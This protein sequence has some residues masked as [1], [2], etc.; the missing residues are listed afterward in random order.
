MAY[1]F[2]PRPSFKELPV[3]YN[4]EGAVGAQPAMNQREDVLL[5]QFILSFIAKTPKPTYSQAMIAA[6]NAVQLTGVADEATITAIREYQKL[7]PGWT[8]DGRVSPAKGYSYSGTMFAIVGLNDGLQNRAI[9]VWPRIDKIPGCPPELAQ[10]VKRAVV[11][12]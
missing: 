9:D 5:V 7:T 6:C 3:F 12:E 1:L 10:M 2:A 4:V 8:V 11:G